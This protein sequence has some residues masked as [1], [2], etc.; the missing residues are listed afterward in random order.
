MK[1]RRLLR[2]AALSGAAMSGLALGIVRP[3]RAAD[4]DVVIVGAGV[5]GL[6]AARALM[7]AH[8]SVLVV[9]ARE[10]IGGQDSSRQGDQTARRQQKIAPLHPFQVKG[11]SCCLT[12]PGGM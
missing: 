8:K 5:A 7:A 6:A 10:R 3:A 2:S 9:E 11:K 1:R 4:L 12:K